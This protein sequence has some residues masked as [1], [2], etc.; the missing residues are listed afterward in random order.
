MATYSM[1]SSAVVK[2]YVTEVGS[3]WVESICDVALNMAERWP[4]FMKTAE[5]N[6]AALVIELESR[7][8][9]IRLPWEL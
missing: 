6:V 2:R 7:G 5:A 3:P 1:D 9:K 4:G 8:Y